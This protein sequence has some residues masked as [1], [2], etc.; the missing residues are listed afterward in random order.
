MSDPFIFAV[1]TAC[2]K[3]GRA[4]A[5]FKLPENRKYHR[6]ARPDIAEEPTIGSRESTPA[7]ERDAEANAELGDRLILRFDDKLKDITRGWQFG[8][9]PKSCDILLGHRGTPGISAKH[10][11]I[12]VT[13]MKKVELY[14]ESKFG[15]VVS[16]NGQSTISAF[17]G[18]KRMLSLNLEK[19]RDWATVK[20]FVP[21]ENKLTFTISFPRRKESQLQYLQNLRTFVQKREKAYP[22]I[23]QL[24]LSDGSP[25]TPG[26]RKLQSLPRE[27]IIYRGKELGRG[28]FSRVYQCIDVTDGEMYA[29]KLFTTKFQRTGNTALRHFDE[30]KW[31]ERI[32]REV[33]IMK[34]NPHVCQDSMPVVTMLT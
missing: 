32:Q 6:K 34:N 7:P 13:R 24:G 21:Y 5:A 28:T 3:S 33:T 16:Y 1:L 25:T 23:S 31:L 11:S 20:V 26:N 9:D 19:Y 29:V 15:T 27:S 8:T 2:D 17:E 10:L 22:M 30:Q 4:A 12:T 14:N 18:D